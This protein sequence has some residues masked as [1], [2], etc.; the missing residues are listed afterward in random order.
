MKTAVSGTSFE[1]PITA[2]FKNGI[3]IGSNNL[4]MYKAKEAVLEFKSA[5]SGRFEEFCRHITIFSASST[6][7]FGLVRENIISALSTVFCNRLHKKASCCFPHLYDHF[8]LLFES[9][10]LWNVR[11]QSVLLFLLILC[12][13]RAQVLRYSK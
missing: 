8:F 2:P 5:Y 13:Y 3:S 11:H 7:F 6:L 4:S 1:A 12:L 9:G 10:K